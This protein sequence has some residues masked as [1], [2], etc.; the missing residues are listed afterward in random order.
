M[1]IVA[2]SSSVRFPVLIS[3]CRPSFKSKV[4]FGS[5]LSSTISVF[6]IVFTFEA[7]TFLEFHMN[8]KFLRL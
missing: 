3:S 5:R 1:T 4:I 2:I 7:L 6:T 8:I